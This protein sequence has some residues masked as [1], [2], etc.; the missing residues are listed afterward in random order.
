[1]KTNGACWTKKE[2]T[3]RAECEEA[4]RT[5]DIDALASVYEE[6]SYCYNHT[7]GAFSE[8]F[9]AIATEAEGYLSDAGYFDYEEEEDERLCF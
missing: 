5:G 8:R 2:P 1:M 7:Q 6:A 3:L 4:V 9:A